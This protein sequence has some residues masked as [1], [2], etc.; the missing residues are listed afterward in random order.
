MKAYWGSGGIAGCENITN[1]CDIFMRVKF[2][3]R[4]S[5]LRRRVASR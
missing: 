2:S 3:S 5:G 1:K 4:S